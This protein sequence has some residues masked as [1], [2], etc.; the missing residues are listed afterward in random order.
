M[1]IAA[2]SGA[3]P[4][5]ADPARSAWRLSAGR[6]VA[7]LRDISRTGIPVDASPV[8][9]RG[10]GLGILAQHTRERGRW[11][12]EFSAVFTQAT[13][14][15]YEMGDITIPRPSDDRFTRTDAHYALHR[16]LFSDVGIRGVSLAAGVRLGL[17]RTSVER[18]VPVD[19]TATESRISAT[20]A[21]VV[22]LGFRRGRGPGLD[23][24]WGNGGHV[25]RLSARHSS[26]QL[27]RT[28][29]GGGWQTD[30]AIEGDIP[31]GRVT[32]LVARYLRSNDG[33]L[34]SHRSVASARSSLSLGVMYGR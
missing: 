3:Q 20:T 29:W 27:T 19:L 30:L 5:T 16:R 13:E 22:T 2:V 10:T 23:V 11:R 12:Q 21:F 6:D 26:D 33:V 32:S 15:H 17:G 18:H 28:Q 1:A 8:S 7:A 14:F 31:I 34:S 4:P 24:E 25:G 9:W